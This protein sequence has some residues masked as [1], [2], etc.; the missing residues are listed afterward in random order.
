[1]TNSAVVVEVTASEE[2]NSPKKQNEYIGLWKTLEIVRKKQKRDLG[3]WERLGI[4]DMIHVSTEI[5]LLLLGLCQ[6]LFSAYCCLSAT[7]FV[8]P[9]LTLLGV[10]F[11]AWSHGSKTALIYNL[12]VVFLLNLGNVFE[13]DRV[14][15]RANTGFFRFSWDTL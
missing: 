5:C 6:F 8:L 9:L 11:Y 14:M 10:I 1:M 7:A 15:D 12:L 4:K 13:A 3:I 2:S